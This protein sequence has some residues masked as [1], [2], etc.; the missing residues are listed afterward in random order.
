MFSK[1]L[2][3]KVG[4]IAVEVST[5]NGIRACKSHGPVFVIKYVGSTDKEEDALGRK[6]FQ[7]HGVEF[8]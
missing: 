8:K 1:N 7:A 4:S 6:F 5:K 3:K 2:P